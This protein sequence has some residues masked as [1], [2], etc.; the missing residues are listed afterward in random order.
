M[1]VRRVNKTRMESKRG[2]DKTIIKQAKEGMLIKKTMK[3]KIIIIPNEDI[4]SALVI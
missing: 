3:R 2:N 1:K 4:E